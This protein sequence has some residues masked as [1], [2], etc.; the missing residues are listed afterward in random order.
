MD[1][2]D[3]RVR[4]AENEQKVPMFADYILLFQEEPDESFVE[5]MFY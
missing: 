1:K 3:C 2:T 4:V 5:L